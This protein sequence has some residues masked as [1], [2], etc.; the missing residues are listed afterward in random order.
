MW[1]AADHF[2]YVWKKVSGD[3]ALEA[4]IEFVGSKPGDRHAGSAPQGVPRHPADARRGLGLCRCRRSRRRA[5]VASVAR[6]ERRRRP[7]KSSRTSSGPSGCGSRSAAATCRCRSPRPAR[8][9]ASGRRIRA[10]RP[11]RRLLRRP[12]RLRSQHR[13]DRDGDVLG[14]DARRR[15]PAGPGKTTLVNTLETISLR[16]KDR[17]VAYVVTQPG[18][19]EAPNWFPGRHQHAVLQ[20][21]RQAVQSAGRTSGTP[22]NPNRLKVPEAVDLGMLTRINNDHGISRTASSGRSA[23][24]RRRST[25]GGHR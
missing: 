7:T 18:R 9:A 24:S 4:T 3:V 20:Q 13:P 16:S 2:H 14:C 19:I 25:A 11:H 10:G 6:R 12:R 17:R 15:R 8:T 23:I 5:D 1:A 22:P 21:R